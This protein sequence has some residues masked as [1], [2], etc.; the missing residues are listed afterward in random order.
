MSRPK[1]HWRKHSTLLLDNGFFS[2]SDARSP[3][4]QPAY[5]QEWA[6]ELPELQLEQGGQS[7]PCSLRRLTKVK[8]LSLGIHILYYLSRAIGADQVDDASFAIVDHLPPNLEALCIYGYE[9]GMKPQVEGL[10][11]DV[12]ERQLEKLLAEKDTRL[13][14]LSYIEGID[15]F[16]ENTTTDKQR[17]IMRICRGGRQMMKGPIMNMIR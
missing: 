9:K 12:F 10:P 13:P 14:R 15:E 2:N 7:S 6:D 4:S 16:I 1:P 8:N 11:D 5:Q 3:R 17:L